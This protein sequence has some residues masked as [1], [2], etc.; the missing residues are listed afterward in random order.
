MRTRTT[1]MAQRDLRVVIGEMARELAEDD[2]KAADWEDID[3]A[4][5]ELRG[6]AKAVVEAAAEARQKMPSASEINVTVAMPP[7][8]GHK[9]S[10]PPST[11]TLDAH[12]PLIGH[13]KA[14]GMRAI[15]AVLAAV[16]LV[17]GIAWAAGHRVAAPAEA[18]H[19][20]D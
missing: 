3:T 9:S 2:A 19:P 20:K 10:E 17:V 4:V 11:A 16:A 12:F 8:H 14:R 6:A 13:V 7:Q 18:A 15:L 5:T 1:A